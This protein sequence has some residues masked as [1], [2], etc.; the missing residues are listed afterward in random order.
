MP[1]LAGNYTDSI[2]EAVQMAREAREVG[3][4]ASVILPP[5][6]LGAF[7]DEVIDPEMAYQWHKTIADQGETPIVLFQY[8]KRTGASYTTDTLKR[9]AEL[10][11][12]IAIK[13]GTGHPIDYEINYRALTAIKPAVPV[14]TTNNS[15][16]LASLSVGGDG[17]M[18]G[19]SSV[20]AELQGQLLKA[21]DSGDLAGARKLNDRLYPVVRAFYR[22]PHI[23]MHLRMKE[24]LVMLGVFSKAT[25]RP[26]LLPVTDQERSEIRAALVAAQLL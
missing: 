6:N 8:N 13:E 15:W 23:N 25:V 12:V 20:L 19:S 22:S 18:S 4:A 3:A 10:E 5:P 21:I 14:L 11:A 16:I 26:P 9:L 7:G 1:V 24:A 2:I 17:I